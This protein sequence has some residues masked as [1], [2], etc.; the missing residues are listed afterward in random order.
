[1]ALTDSR[2]RR[3]HRIRERVRHVLEAECRSVQLE[4]LMQLCC[5]RVTDLGGLTTNL[6]RSH[7]GRETV[8][9]VEFVSE[10][11]SP[12]SATVTTFTKKQCSQQNPRRAIH[13][14]ERKDVRWGT[15]IGKIGDL[16]LDCDWQILE[17][18]EQR[19]VLV[20]NE[21]QLL[22]SLWSSGEDS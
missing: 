10:P 21:S 16:H 1:M 19:L 11:C 12:V 3:I 9:R 2:C 22:G 6:E 20:A 14:I 4:E 17:P 15:D 8:G 5:H 13:R 18:P 7:L